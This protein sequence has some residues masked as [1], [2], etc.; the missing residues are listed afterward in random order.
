MV[1]YSSGGPP[2]TVKHSRNL[3]WEK[4]D[5][6][7]FLSPVAHSVNV[8]EYFVVI[9]ENIVLKKVPGNCFFL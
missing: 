2:V 5:Y 4:N 7:F 6:F 3:M 8:I 1:T 9:N